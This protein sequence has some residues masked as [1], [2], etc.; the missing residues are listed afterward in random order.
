LRTDSAAEQT[1]AAGKKTMLASDV[2][3]AL[4]ELEF[5][6][7]LPRVEAETQREFLYIYS[8]NDCIW[9]YELIERWVR[10]YGYTER[11]EEFLQ[12]DEKGTS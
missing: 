8:N 1:A 6:S 9:V 10:V 3:A 4:R 2:F 11:Q 7:F 12:E 5:E